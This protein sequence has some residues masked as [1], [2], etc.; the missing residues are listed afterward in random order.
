MKRATFFKSKSNLE[1]DYCDLCD[2]RF[3]N[4]DDASWLAWTS[5]LHESIE[6][7]RWIVYD[8]LAIEIPQRRPLE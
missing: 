7:T 4:A 6:S 1:G 8:V 5:L 2:C 3:S